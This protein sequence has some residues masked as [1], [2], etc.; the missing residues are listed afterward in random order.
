MDRSG[1]PVMLRFSELSLY[2]FHRMTGD[3]LCFSGLFP[4]ILRHTVRIKILACQITQQRAKQQSSAKRAA[5]MPS[6]E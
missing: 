6:S 3:S 1:P 2:G 5:M 4:D